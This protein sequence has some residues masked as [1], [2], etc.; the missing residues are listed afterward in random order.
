MSTLDETA[1]ASKREAASYRLYPFSNGL[2]LANLAVSSNILIDSWN[3][4]SGHRGDILEPSLSTIQTTISLPLSAHRS[5]QVIFKKKAVRFLYRSLTL[6]C[7]SYPPIL[8]HL[9]R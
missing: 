9:F 2:Y 7:S 3:A 5:L 8:I 4:I 6:A 1:S